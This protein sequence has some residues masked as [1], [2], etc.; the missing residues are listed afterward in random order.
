MPGDVD[1]RRWY[2][3]VFKCE[4]TNEV[5]MLISTQR[6][7]NIKLTLKFTQYSSMGMDEE[8][9]HLISKRALKYRELSF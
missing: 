9:E 6:I 8:T 2:D 4:D 7:H 5:H 3:N 1:V